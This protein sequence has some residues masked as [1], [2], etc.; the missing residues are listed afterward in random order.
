MKELS[1]G[2]DRNGVEQAIDE[3]HEVLFELIARLGRET[4]SAKEIIAAIDALAEET[5]AHFLEEEGLMR[6]LGYPEIDAHMDAH[7]AFRQSLR[8]LRAAYGDGPKA[9][10][11]DDVDTLALADTLRDWLAEH[12][13][14]LDSPFLAYLTRYSHP[15]GA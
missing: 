2:P 4:A 11:R 6:R 13:L 12:F 15:R 1:Q 7:D 5:E 14:A 10:G 3:T 8:N 9:D